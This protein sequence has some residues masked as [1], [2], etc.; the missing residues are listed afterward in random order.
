MFKFYF[1]AVTYGIAFLIIGVCLR[2]LVVNGDFICKYYLFFGAYVSLFSLVFVCN[3]LVVNGDFK[4]SE[5]K[6]IVY[7]K[8]LLYHFFSVAFCFLLLYAFRYSPL[9]LPS[10]KELNITGKAALLLASSLVNPSY[11]I[12]Y[13]AEYICALPIP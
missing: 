6:Y 5:A 1:S 8:A 3:K 13:N 12:L 10:S 7:T 11:S 9:G 2:K 4:K